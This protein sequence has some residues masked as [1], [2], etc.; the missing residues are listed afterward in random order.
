MLQQLDTSLIVLL[1]LLTCGVLGQNH[2]ISAAAAILILIKISPFNQIIFPYIQQYGLNLGILILTVAVL[3]PIASGKISG[4]MVLKSFVSL[5]SIAAIAI[6]IF[7]AWVGGRGVQLMTLQ[8][9]VVAGLVIGTVI[10]VAFFRGV[11]VGPLI[12]AGLLSLFYLPK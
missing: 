9:N 5:Q 4:E 8:P 6:G 10:G 7:V 1:I 12:A 2:T 3:M 11:P